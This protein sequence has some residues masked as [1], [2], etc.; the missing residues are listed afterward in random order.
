MSNMQLFN[1]NKKLYTYKIKIGLFD[2]S[3]VGRVIKLHINTHLTH[4]KSF[5]I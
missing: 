4:I 1:N 2:L 3:V 5:E